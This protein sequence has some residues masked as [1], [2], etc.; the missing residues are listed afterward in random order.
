ML[1]GNNRAVLYLLE[2]I[3]S[4]IWQRISFAHSSLSF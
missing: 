2:D 4:I 3:N 1:K